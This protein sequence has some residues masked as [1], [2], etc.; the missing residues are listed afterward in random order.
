M[1][2]IYARFCSGTW[3]AV[4]EWEVLIC[5]CTLDP[6]FH[7]GIVCCYGG[8]IIRSRPYARGRDKLRSRDDAYIKYASVWDNAYEG[9]YNGQKK[10]G[11]PLYP[12]QQITGLLSS[13][14][15]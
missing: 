4:Q 11:Q 12:A 6:K 14:L 2:H 7:C 5:L 3:Y 9:L 1:S 10:H 13:P 15:I 8:D